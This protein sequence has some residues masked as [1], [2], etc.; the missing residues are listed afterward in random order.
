MAVAINTTEWT[1]SAAGEVDAYPNL[2]GAM[3]ANG[4]AV[5]V[6]TAAPTPETATVA[7]FRSPCALDPGFGH[8]GAI[9]LALPGAGVAVGAV[10][11]TGDGGALLA[12]NT[13]RGD[14][15][16]VGKLTA[17]GALDPSFGT[18]GWSV[19]PWRGSADAIAVTRAG[20]IVLGGADRP[21]E[22]GQSMV[23]EVTARGRVVPTFGV[24]GR[25]AMPGYHDGGLESV[26]VEPSGQI[27]ALVGGGNMGCWGVTA[28]TLSP[29]GH[30][31]RGFTERF[32]RA[33]LL[34]DPTICWTPVFVGDTQVGPTGFRLIGTAERQCVNYGCTEHPCSKPD[35][36]QRV[37]EIA[38]T[39]EGDLDSG[40]GA[41]GSTSTPAPMAES[42]WA[43]PQADGS[44][45]LAATPALACLN[46]RKRAELF[47]YHLTRTGRLD[48]SYADRGVD[49]IPQPYS[50]G[51]YIVSTPAIPVSNGRTSAIIVLTDHGNAVGLMSAP[52]G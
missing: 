38:F 52:A 41:G 10:A 4:D 18:R 19:L 45:L 28:V 39:Y 29:S 14:H 50:N 21:H 27:L 48:R 7:E 43:M 11:P 47:V 13:D 17:S 23:T 8:A 49:T 44:V 3:L 9:E 1:S 12:G 42:A 37:T 5:A 16:L 33:L 30:L 20:D 15:W 40:F 26:A 24:L 46:D 34:A 2:T 22:N 6:A 32:Q 36:T 25:V 31:L 51:Q 35:P